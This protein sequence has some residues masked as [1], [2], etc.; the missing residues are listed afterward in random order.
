MSTKRFCD[1]CGDEITMSNDLRPLGDATIGS[2]VGRLCGA[3]ERHGPGG[4]DRL[5]VEIVTGQDSTWNRGD[6]CRYC[7]ID[8]V[9]SLDDRPKPEFRP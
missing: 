3:H 9:S 4:R 7:V 2:A 1:H 5:M 8:A 6:Y